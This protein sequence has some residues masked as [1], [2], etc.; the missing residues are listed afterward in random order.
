MRN[1]LLN[2]IIY[3]L[4]GFYL[5]IKKNFFLLAHNSNFLPAPFAA[6]STILNRNGYLVNQLLG[7]KFKNKI[8]VSTAVTS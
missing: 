8:S 3:F 6:A 5:N 4:L 2:L 1:K 7:K